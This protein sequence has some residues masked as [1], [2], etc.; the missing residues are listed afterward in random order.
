MVHGAVPPRW[1]EN[2][3]G[4]N[5]RQEDNNNTLNTDMASTEDSAGDTPDTTPQRSKQHSHRSPA[6]KYFTLNDEEQMVSCKL[7]KKSYSYNKNTSVM[8]RPS[9]KQAS[10]Q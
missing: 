2:A 6:W 5:V 1:R 9:E 3:N 4:K 7:C 8:L 10:T